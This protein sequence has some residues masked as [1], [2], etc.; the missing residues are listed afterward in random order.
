L[1]R[2]HT[3]AEE[4]T[5]DPQKHHPPKASTTTAQ[6]QIQISKTKASL[7]APPFAATTTT[8]TRSKIFLTK[9]L[10]KDERRVPRYRWNKKSATKN[11]IV[12]K[13]KKNQRNHHKK[14]KTHRKRATARTTPKNKTIK[15]KCSLNPKTHPKK[16]T[17]LPKTHYQS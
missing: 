16:K 12:T 5:R 10:C 7:L 14:L 6:I 17:S 3:L 2:I 13:Q 11:K 1:L 15:L 4:R 9:F 8:T